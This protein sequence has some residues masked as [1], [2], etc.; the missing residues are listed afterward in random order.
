MPEDVKEMGYRIITVKQQWKQGVACC[1]TLL[2]LKLL[3]VQKAQQDLVRQDSQKL[4][5]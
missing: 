5:E 1:H 2:P 3:Q 4:V